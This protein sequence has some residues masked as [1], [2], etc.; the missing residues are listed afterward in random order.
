[1]DC[2]ETQNLIDPYGDGELDLV[3]N[4]EIDRHLEQCA[5]CSESYKN[6]QALRHG[7]KADSLYYRPSTA[8]RSRIQSSLRKAAKV[9]ASPRA[10]FRRWTGIAVSMAVAALVVLALLPVLR[11]S[12]AEDRLTSEVLSGH[13]R[14]LM[15]NHLAD[16]SSSDQHTVKPW[17]AGKLDFSPP[18]EDFAQQGFPL[19]GG[20]LDYLENRPVAA[21]VYERR[22]HLI[23]L[24]VWPAS[25]TD[26]P[27]KAVSR[28]GYNLIH[29]TQSRMTYWA[30]SDLD[31]N[32]LQEFVQLVQNRT[33]PRP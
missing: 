32:E 8:L 11:G 19:I 17:F 24:F 31:K 1:M 33:S 6:H 30:A 29:W 9:E 25:E 18:V 5:P 16:I 23:N 20:R 21:L 27:T 22:K 7:L 3:K 12:S 14:S 26:V 4:L 13:L 15:A 10:V 2:K 28:L